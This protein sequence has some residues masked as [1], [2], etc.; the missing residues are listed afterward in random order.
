MTAILGVDYGE[1]RIGLALSDE[2]G[3]L[4]FPY[5]ILENNKGVVNELVILLK[6]RGISTVV[7]GE[8]L[9]AEGVPNEIMKW[10]KYF[11]EELEEKGGVVC[12]FEP[13]FFTSFHAAQAEHNQK[14]L[15]ASAAAL[16]LQRYLD[17]TNG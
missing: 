17:K 10:A 2:S 15:D 8:S 16:I 6:K 12:I 1:K 3:K 5:K 4:A 13:E 11:K 14:K 7:L 9:N